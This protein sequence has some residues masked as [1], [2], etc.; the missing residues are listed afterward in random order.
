[1]L[2]IVG[3]SLPENGLF[4]TGKLNSRRPRVNV[5]HSLTILLNC[6]DS[7]N[8]YGGADRLTNSGGGYEL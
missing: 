2:S 1:M 5:Q 6:Q 7:S 3:I 8:F 4:L